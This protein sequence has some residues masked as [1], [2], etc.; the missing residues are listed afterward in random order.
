MPPPMLEGD[1]LG[2]QL[3]LESRRALK[4]KILCPTHNPVRHDTAYLS[5]LMGCR[6]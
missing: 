6:N 5:G 4:T 3:E 2:T 1:P